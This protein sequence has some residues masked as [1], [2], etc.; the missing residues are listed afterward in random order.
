MVME[1]VGSK[2]EVGA[3]TKSS[4]LE[5]TDNNV[6]TNLIVQVPC[7]YWVSYLTLQ[8]NLMN[9]PFAIGEAKA[10][11]SFDQIYFSFSTL[12]PFLRWQP[13][14][15]QWPCQTGATLNLQSAWFVKKNFFLAC[16]CILMPGVF[17]HLTR[18]V[19]H[20]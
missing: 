4:A 12:V 15:Q 17:G 20:S 9:V 19:S 7:V 2:E 14:L 11:S 16:F 8:G 13:P 1:I 3:V 6:S 18:L 10:F 5:E